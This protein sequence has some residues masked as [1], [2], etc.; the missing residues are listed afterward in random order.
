[1]QQLLDAEVAQDREYMVRH[2]GLC[3]L[4]WV[5]QRLYCYSAI[6]CQQT[7]ASLLSFTGLRFEALPV[8]LAA[9][10]AWQKHCGDWADHLIG[11]QMR[12]LGCVAVMTLDKAAGKAAGKAG[13][14]RLV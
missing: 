11:A 13:T 2:V 5:L 6:Q 4:V 10:K 14:H 12:A 3:E 7:I 9:Y 8:L 1:V